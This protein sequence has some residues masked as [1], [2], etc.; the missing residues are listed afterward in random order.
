M[1]GEI[2]SSGAYYIRL[3]TYLKCIITVWNYRRK[4]LPD[5]VIINNIDILILELA[6]SFFGRAKIVLEISDLLK[7][8]FSTGLI[9]KFY[10]SLDQFLVSNFVNCLVVTSIKY[11]DYYYSNFYLGPCFE[12]EN[13][14]LKI[15][16]PAIL[17]KDS[18]RK[19]IVIGLVGLIYQSVPLCALLKAAINDNRVEVHIYGQLYDTENCKEIIENYCSIYSNIIFKGSYDF[20]RDSA[21]IYSSIDLLY[22]SYDTSDDISN[23]FLA[24]PNK[25]YEAMYYHIPIIASKGTY[26]AERVMISGIGYEIDCGDSNQITDIISSFHIRKKSFEDAFRL[27]MPNTYLGDNDYY[28]FSKFILE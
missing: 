14:P 7:F 2:S 26:L 6:T 3:I 15:S 23:N 25:L 17:Q 4:L 12:L 13:K 27:L 8:V 16:L 10:R 5:I 24:L 18:N 22:V 19:T 28:Q 9:A 21:R 20:F 11:Y 1:V